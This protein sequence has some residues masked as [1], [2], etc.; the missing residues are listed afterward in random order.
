MSSF[1]KLRAGARITCMIV[2]VQILWFMTVNSFPVSDKIVRL[3]AQPK[4]RFQQF[5]GHITVD[6]KQDRAL[7]YYLVEAEKDPLSKPL[8][9]WL[10]GGKIFCISSVYMY[11]RSNFVSLPDRRSF[12]LMY[13]L[14]QLIMTQLI[15]MWLSASY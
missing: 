1:L 4:V 7:F 5:S 9:L 2:L 12:P 14:L 3:P 10:N 11:G 15:Y 13:Q 8:V 6:E